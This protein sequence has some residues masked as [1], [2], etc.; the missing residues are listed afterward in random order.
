MD[1]NWNFAKTKKN[2]RGY[3][4]D[5]FDVLSSRDRLSIVVKPFGVDVPRIELVIDK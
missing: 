5:V 3:L 4:V 1:M 2:T